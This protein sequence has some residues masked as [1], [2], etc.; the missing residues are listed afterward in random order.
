MN[1]Y[2]KQ[3]TEEK[4]G[5]SFGESWRYGEDSLV[6]LLPILRISKALRKYILLRE[7][8]DVEVSDT[9]NI[10]KVRVFN[11]EKKPVYI[12]MGE[13]FTG[14]T[15]ERTAVRSYIVM[16]KEKVDIEVRCVY[17]SKGIIASQ[18]MTSGGIGSSTTTRA[19]SKS[20]FKGRSTNQGEVWDKIRNDATSM[21]SCAVNMLVSD[22]IDEIKKDEGIEDISNKRVEIIQEEVKKDVPNFTDDLKGNIEK[23]SKVI[24]K[25]LQ[26]VPY[27]EN[28]VGIA[29]LDLKGVNGIELFD[30][31]GSWKA[32][33]DDII[34]KEGE[35]LS[36][37]Q[38]DS[39]FEY[40]K[41]KAVRVVKAILSL[42]FEERVSFKSADY[43]IINLNSEKYTGEITEL[44][45]KMIHCVLIR[46]QN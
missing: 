45:E 27:F 18:K 44:N 25:V 12:R 40:K 36:K 10:N 16:P 30:L 26:K 4:N 6:A 24:E 29:T 19:F 39:P 23:F 11:G 43:K 15:Q 13:I 41:S 31:K 1:K 17:A 35:N 37:E 5:F 20:A 21:Y 33:R 34:K 7:A 9:G 46:K 3:I 28:Q 42:D 14:K 32:F 22:R 2:L 38:K 8:E